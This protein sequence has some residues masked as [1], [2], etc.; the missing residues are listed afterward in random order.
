MLVRHARHRHHGIH[1]V[2]L[3][4]VKTEA[5]YDAN[6]AGTAQ[7]LLAQPMNIRAQLRPN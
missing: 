3:W 1:G 6:A 2:L 7:W 5:L 4:K